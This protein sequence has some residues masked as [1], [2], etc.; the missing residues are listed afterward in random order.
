MQ[1]VYDGFKRL[2][3]AC[4]ESSDAEAFVCKA[5][6]SNRLL[7]GKTATY[8]VLFSGYRRGCHHTASTGRAVSK[9]LDMLTLTLM[10]QST[11]AG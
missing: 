6:E 4:L 3:H 10:I 9:C 7:S 2:L 5:V 11:T 1:R 8:L